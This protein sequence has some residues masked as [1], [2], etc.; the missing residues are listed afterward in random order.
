MK[1]YLSRKL[2]AL[3]ILTLFISIAITSCNSDIVSDIISN[4]VTAKDRLD[5]A[6]S[7]EHRERPNSQ[8]VLIFGRNVKP[9][10]KTDM[11]ALNVI[12][13]GN[14]E[15][16]GSWLY[17]F[18]SPNDTSIKVYTP[19]PTP[20]ARDCINLT[21]F[22]DINTIVNL[23]PDTSA[24]NII[25]GALQLVNG[26]NTIKINTPTD[27]L[28]D[29]DAS[30]NIANNTSPILKFNSNYQLSQSTTNGNKFF[31]SGTQQTINMFL[32]PAAGTLNLPDFIQDLIGFPQDV[33]ISNYKKNLSG[34]QKNLVLATIVQNNQLMGI[35]GTQFRTKVINVSKFAE[36]LP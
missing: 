20:G 7:Q 33:W 29:S 18:K 3:T 1:N 11:T 2:I 13:N 6:I 22:F 24:A 15:S 25:K 28:I 9:N 32:I 21:A 23:I 10:G 14:T 12:L 16:I 4:E 35:N 26:A 31:Q 30:L 34:I 36:E 8:L 19:N 5:S 27:A 17:V